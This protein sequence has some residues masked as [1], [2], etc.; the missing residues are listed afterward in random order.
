MKILVNNKLS[1][2][3]VDAEVMELKKTLKQVAKEKPNQTVEN[4][5]SKTD[6]LRKVVEK[7]QKE[8]GPRYVLLV[9]KGTEDRRKRGEEKEV[10]GAE[11]E[12]RAE[13]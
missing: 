13:E 9:K 3:V 12:G 6:T 4:T 5:L 10:Q 11:T 1:F 2:Q 8:T 7:N